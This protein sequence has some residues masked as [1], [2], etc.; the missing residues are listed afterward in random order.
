VN[1]STDRLL[2]LDRARVLFHIERLPVHVA[3][4][5]QGEVDHAQPT[6]LLVNRSIRM[7]PPVRLSS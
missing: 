3:G 5:A 7:K 1:H 4:P 2:V 6:V